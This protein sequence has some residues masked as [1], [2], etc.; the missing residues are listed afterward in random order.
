M[1]VKPAKQYENRQFQAAAAIA[2][3]QLLKT[4]NKPKAFRIIVLVAV[5]VELQLL[6]LSF[7]ECVLNKPQINILIQRHTHTHTYIG[8]Q[9]RA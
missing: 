7:A 8:S 5:V 1:H 2:A 6:L 9:Q 4:I 3:T